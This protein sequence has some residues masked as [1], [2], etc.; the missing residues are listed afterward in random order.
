MEEIL[1]VIDHD[2][3]R[4]YIDPEFRSMSIIIVQMYNLLDV[5]AVQRY[6]KKTW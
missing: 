1:S 5:K 2:K 4:Y 3:L 6:F